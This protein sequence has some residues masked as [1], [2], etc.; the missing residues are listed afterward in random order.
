ME[1]MENLEHDETGGVVNF[2]KSNVV[3]GE[4][5]KAVDDEDTNDGGD[6]DVEQ[7]S[8]S[9]P[10]NVAGGMSRGGSGLSQ[11]DI[12]LSHQG[13]GINSYKKARVSESRRSIVLVTCLCSS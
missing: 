3:G 13:D 1:W 10:P 5:N 4:S 9:S 7:V 2:E 12:S 8:F 6:E 11:D